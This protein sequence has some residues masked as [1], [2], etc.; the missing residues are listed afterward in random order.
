MTRITATMATTTAITIITATMAI[1][2]KIKITTT[3]TTTK[4]IVIQWLWSL[5][6]NQ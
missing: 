6:Y 2:T 3:I 1:T 5:S 4:A